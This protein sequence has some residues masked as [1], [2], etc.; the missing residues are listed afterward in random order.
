MKNNKKQQKMHVKKGETVQVISGK[1]KGK[2]GK[3]TKILH[4]SS[5]II[6]ANINI[7]TKHIKAQKEANNGK[8]ITTEMPIH[9]SKVMLYSIKNQIASRYYTTLN[10]SNKK[11]KV[12]KKNNETV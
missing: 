1:D 10:T 2:I 6:V 9:S 4:K 11:Q 8:I 5:K 12:L 7:R 3:I